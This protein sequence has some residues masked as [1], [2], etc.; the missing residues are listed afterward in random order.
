MTNL[1]SYND[2]RDFKKTKEP[3]GKKSHSKKRLRFVVQHHMARREHY[4]LRLELDG[5]LKSWAVPKGPSYDAK[6]KRL[7]VEVEDHPIS[8]R[9]FEGTIPKGQYGGGT[10][11]VWDEGYWEPLDNPK[12]DF[13]NGSIKFIIHGK[14][15]KGKWT[16]IRY[17]E[18]NW[19]LIKEKDGIK[20]FSNIDDFTTSIKTGRTMTEIESGQKT[21]SKSEKEKNSLDEIEITN[22][23]KVIFSS[24]KVTKN[25]I[26][27]YYKKVSKRMLPYLE[28]RIMSTIRYPNGKS[29]PFFKKHFESNKDLGCIKLSSKEGK[30]DDY[31]YI[32]EASN[33]IREVQMNGYEFHIWGS[34]IDALNRP[35]M[36]VFDL[37]PDETMDIRDVR[38]GVK[39]LKSILD[40]FSLKSFLKTSGGKGYHVVVPLKKHHSW[41]KF[42]EIAENIAKLMEAKWPEKYTSNI[43]KDSRKGKIFIDWLR[44]TK[45]ASS[46]APYSLRIRENATVS[47]PIRWS[48]LDKVK[49]DEITIEEA[50]KR[51][52]RKDPWENFFRTNL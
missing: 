19:L 37:D 30:K 21:K 36:L 4:D 6:D 39:D 45:G 12:K 40:E 26:A 49:P 13:K 20:L 10:V 29:K 48:E 3:V 31:Y 8:Y 50:I 17:K 27:K 9:N 23:Q 24:P 2:K 1:K 42:R 7:A 16:L 51:L 52:K 34:T 33:I 5:V 18:D 28:K 11:M 43:R 25:D 22:P 32:K 15:L 46:V 41:E 35:D 38:K 44:N 47:M 14:R